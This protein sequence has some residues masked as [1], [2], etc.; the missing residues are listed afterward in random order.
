LL[1][2]KFDTINLSSHVH[3]LTGIHSYLQS[4]DSGQANLFSDVTTKK[5]ARI[6]ISNIYFQLDLLLLM[7]LSAI[8]MGEG[9]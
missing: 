6:I 1:Q 5:N 7:C 2:T 9:Y 8:Y 3:N 4:N